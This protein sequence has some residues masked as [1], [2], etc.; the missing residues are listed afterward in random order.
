LLFARAFIKHKGMEAIWKL[1]TTVAM[2]ALT[3]VSQDMAPATTAVPTSPQ[4]K[5]S[6]SGLPG[7]LILAKSEHEL[8]WA[9]AQE[10]VIKIA[11]QIERMAQQSK[12]IPSHALAPRGCFSCAPSAVVFLL[13]RSTYM[14]SFYSSCAVPHLCRVVV[15][16]A[17]LSGLLNQCTG[18]SKGLDLST[19][20][21]LLDRTITFFVTNTF[22]TPEITVAL[23]QTLVNA[24][25]S[26]K[27]RRGR[28]EA[29]FPGIKLIIHVFVLPA[30]FTALT[31]CDGYVSKKGLEQMTALVLMH[32]GNAAILAQ[33]KGWSKVFGVL[34]SGGPAS[35]PLVTSNSQFWVTHRPPIWTAPDKAEIM[36]LSVN[37]I[38]SVLY[39]RFCYPAE[40]EKDKENATPAPAAK[41]DKDAPLPLAP[42]LSFLLSAFSDLED[43][44]GWTA[45]TTNLFRVLLS[46][47]M[48]ILLSRASNLKGDY[49]SKAW[50][51][52]FDLLDACE[53]FVFYSP[54]ES[55]DEKPRPA[56]KRQF[57]E[58]GA[59]LDAA[60]NPID[61]PIVHRIK[62]LLE[63]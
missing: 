37:M 50:P 38:V 29:D 62:D 32:G 48:T 10:W 25:Q 4:A 5:H 1:I 53:N 13:S 31:Y 47:F 52:L 56:P 46:A 63:A 55:N 36:K 12:R 7:P 61:Q 16:L 42:Y 33:Q 18:C 23:F 2:P 54:V 3:V 24:I 11:F 49:D 57:E 22:V 21:G 28:P 40:K 27:E 15:C 6:I 19:P 30:L 58:L 51:S 43:V 9:L 8:N 17:W 60:N 20:L 26:P 45:M 14:A 41:A 44:L 59:H 35:D 39:H 34:C